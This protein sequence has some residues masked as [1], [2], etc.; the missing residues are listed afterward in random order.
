MCDDFSCAG[1]VGTT[2]FGLDGVNGVDGVVVVAVTG[3]DA[4]FVCMEEVFIEED[5][6]GSILV[7]V[8]DIPFV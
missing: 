1:V 6:V 8:F 2:V 3:V 7:G 4:I 5:E